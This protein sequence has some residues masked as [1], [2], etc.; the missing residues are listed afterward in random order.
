MDSGKTS[1]V[2]ILQI[3]LFLSVF[4]EHSFSKAGL[5]YNIEQSSVSRYISA[6]EKTLEVQLFQRD[7]R[8]IC[9]TRQAEILYEQW[10]PL[11]QS[12][13]DSV[14]SIES[15]EEII[16][17]TMDYLSFIPEIPEIRRFLNSR[18]INCNVDIKYAAF[19]EWEKILR[20]GNADM[21]IA[22]GNDHVP[23]NKDFIYEELLKYSNTICMLKTN[24]LSSKAQIDYSDLADQNLVTIDPD[25]HFNINLT[26]K[27][28]FENTIGTVPNIV[29]TIS[30]PLGLSSSLEAD[31]E[32][33]F[34]GD[35]IRKSSSP[36]VKYY[37]LPGSYSYLYAIR[38]RGHTPPE[39]RNVI[40]A[41][42]EYFAQ[43]HPE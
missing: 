36:L 42:K 2:S 12:Y 14:K 15:H 39:L 27:G 6:L 20:D 5:K 24:P 10:K 35:F 40:T 25:A 3:Q 26:L 17:Y 4:E 8:P 18:H 16:V 13:N 1:Y 7:T 33:A 11:V 43:Y 38:R 32:V 37:E 28:I 31:N 22:M 29:R 30:S 21:V 34:C 23:K 9:P 41:F 19:A